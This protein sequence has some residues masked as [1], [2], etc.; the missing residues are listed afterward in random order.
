MLA[1]KYTF[2]GRNS[3]SVN[4]RRMVAHAVISLYRQGQRDPLVGEVADYVNSRDMAGANDLEPRKVGS[5]LSGIDIARRDRREGRY[6]VLDDEIIGSLVS[7][8][9]EP[10]DP[11]HARAT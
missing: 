7:R 2:Y 4:V 1:G 9:G 8:F 3:G 5:I 10:G 6:L 11:L